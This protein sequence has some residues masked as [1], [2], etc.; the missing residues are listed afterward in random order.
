M[1]YGLLSGIL[2][3]LDTVILGLFL[4]HVEGMPL[5]NIMITAPFLSTFF[6]DLASALWMFMYTLIRNRLP[7]LVEALKTR[8]AKVIMIGALLGGPVGMTGYVLAIGHIGPGYTA[9]ISAI[10]PAVG[11]MLASLFLKEVFRPRQWVGLL[12]SISAIIA[13]SYSSSNDISNFVLGVFLALLSVIGWAGEGV[14]CSYG[15]R[16]ENVGDEQA[17]IIR[18]STSALVFAALILPLV[19]AWGQAIQI[20][21]SRTILLYVLLAGLAGGFSYLFYYRAIHRI[22]VGK[23]MALNITYSTWAVIFDYLFL[24]NRP[25]VLNLILCVLIVLGALMAAY[26]KDEVM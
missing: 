7:A 16:D 25:G 21:S 17:I 1:K 24:G 12:I 6:H 4:G 18:Q 26:E 10:Y 20:T 2:W 14:I 13:L 9:V 15:M 8:N 11:A 23:S 3:G 22:G 5:K 19:K